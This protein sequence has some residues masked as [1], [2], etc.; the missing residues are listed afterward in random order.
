MMKKIGVCVGATKP[1]KVNFVSAEPLRIGQ[2]V[3]LEYEENGEKYKLLGMIQQLIREN[4][5]I[6]D[7]KSFEEAEKLKRF[8]HNTN[9][10]GEIQILGKIVENQNEIFLEIQRTPPLPGSDIYEADPE[11]LKKLFGAKNERYIKIGRLLSEKNDIPVY[12][13]ISQ[14]ALRHLAILAITG[15]GKSNTVGVLLKNIVNLGGTVIV[16]DFHGEYSKTKFTRDGKEVI[17]QIKPIINPAKLKIDEFANLVGIS[18]K[19]HVQ[20]RYFR[21]AFKK[22]IEQLEDEKG[23]D[24]YNYIDTDDFIERFKL[25]LE[26]LD[27]SEEIKGLKK[28]SLYEVINKLEDTQSEL[29][30]II[31][32]GENHLIEKIKHGYINVIDFSEIDENVADAVASNILKVALEERK[33]AVRQEESKLPYPVIIVV[34]EAHILAS[35]KRDTQSK[36]YMTRIAREGR[37]FGIGLTIVTQ[38]PK[39]LDKEILSQMNNM[40]ILKLVEPEDQKHVQSASEA[41][42]AELMEYLPALNPG[43]AIIIGNMTKLPLLIKIDKAEEKIQGNDIDIISK[44]KESLKNES[45]RRKINLEDL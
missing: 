21:I 30:H 18:S 9:I 3:I 32:I 40:I 10:K 39:G 36:Y 28:D 5:Y 17:N 20:R 24:W 1:N 34:E 2:F 13:D 25:V 27:E 22:L 38:R 35:D 31:K 44:W 41:L 43:E 16:F 42:S 15:A 37:K 14:V 29:G 23:K 4:L 19:A 6:S 11:I 12:I 33:K 8:V 26:S 45:S 7:G